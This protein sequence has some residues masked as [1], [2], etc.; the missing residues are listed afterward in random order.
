MSDVLSKKQR[1]YCMSQ[2][3]GKNTGPEIVLRKALW[4]MGYRYRV[5]NK[6]PGK[7]DIVY[8]SLKIVIFVDGCFWHKCPNHYQPPKTRV[9]FW[10]NK[11]SG[12][13]ERDKKNNM[14]LQSDGWHVI[15]VWEHEIKDS[16]STCVY[17]I[18]ETLS[19]QKSKYCLT[20][21]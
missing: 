16:L 13:V 19:R 14:L 5:K 6:L 3:Q 12:N 1:S 15:R 17:Q 2:I 8:P 21:D 10:K 11:I 4:N 18:S 20:T 7:P 9:S